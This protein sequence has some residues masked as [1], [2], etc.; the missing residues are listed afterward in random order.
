VRVRVLEE[1]CKSVVEF[2]EDVED[3]DTG[4]EC[5]FSGE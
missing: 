4:G 5:V 3:L 1:I 2:V